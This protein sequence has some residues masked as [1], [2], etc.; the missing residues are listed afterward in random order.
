M[1]QVD[2]FAV[3]VAR[4]TGA[5]GGACPSVEKCA[6]TPA[7]SPDTK[8]SCGLCGLG[9][10]AVKIGSVLRGIGDDSE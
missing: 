3:G 8:L 4:M 6:S 2:D 10:N 5:R 7:D 9:G 1:G